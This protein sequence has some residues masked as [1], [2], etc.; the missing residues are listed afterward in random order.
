[1]RELTPLDQELLRKAVLKYLAM[2]HP[3]GFTLESIQSILKSRGLIDWD[4]SKES[5]HSALFILRDLALVKFVASP[6]GASYYWSCTAQ[7]KIA[8]ERDDFSGDE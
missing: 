7:G 6:I 5:V 2:H 1:M 3:A 4:P 8:I